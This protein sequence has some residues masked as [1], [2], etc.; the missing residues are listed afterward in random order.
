MY[1]LKGKMSIAELLPRKFVPIYMPK[2][3]SF[4]PSFIP[5]LLNTCYMMVI[6]LGAGNI[7]VSRMDTHP[8]LRKL[9]F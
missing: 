8:G 1:S 4:I 7:V 9:K 6:I 3:S 5:C 2:K